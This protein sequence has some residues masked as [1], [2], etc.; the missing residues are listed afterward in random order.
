M[1]CVAF[2]SGLAAPELWSR[3]RGAGAFL[4]LSEHDGD[5]IP[6]LEAF[7]FRLPVIARDAALDPGD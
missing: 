2:E 1:W 4:C 5:C 6:L 3:Y 7:H